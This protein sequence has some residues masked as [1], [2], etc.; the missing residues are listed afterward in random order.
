MG[1]VYCGLDFDA[2]AIKRGRDRNVWIKNFA[3]DKGTPL[4][5]KTGRYWEDL[6]G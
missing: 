4:W 6:A 1:A 3:L 2:E 5:H